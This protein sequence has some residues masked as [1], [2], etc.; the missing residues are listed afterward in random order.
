MERVMEAKLS[1]RAER[2]EVEGMR[3]EG[4]EVQDG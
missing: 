1:D 3:G 4:G 2:E